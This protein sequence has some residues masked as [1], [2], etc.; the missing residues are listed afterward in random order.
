MPVY[1]LFP[2][3]VYFSRLDRELTKGELKTINA[4]KIKTYKNV[5]NTTSDD[6]YIL[7]NKA[8]KNLKKDLYKKVLDYFDKVV[9]T[10]N[11][12]VPYI[13]QSWLNYT[14]A[15][16]FHHMHNHANSYVSAV[17]Y[18]AANNKIDKIIFHRPSAGPQRINL[19]IDKWNTFNSQTWFYTVK[20]GDLILFPSH[21]THGVDRKKKEETDTRIALSFNVFIK[22]TIG[23]KLQLTELIL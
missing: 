17:Y 19:N 14:E 2:E 7:N 1:Q 21:L 4:Q 18:I 13:T 11:S 10:K 9:C 16:Q 8:L 22:G 6:T 3:H 15:N 12:I 23:N 5:G 20:T